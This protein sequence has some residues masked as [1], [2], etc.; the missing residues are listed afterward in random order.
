LLTGTVGFETVVREM[1]KSRLSST[2]IQEHKMDPLNYRELKHC[3]LL[4]HSYNS[5]S[6]PA[7]TAP[8]TR[9][10]FFHLVGMLLRKR[11]IDLIQKTLEGEIFIWR[12]KKYL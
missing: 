6:V 3:P 12:N 8:V 1:A 7:S 5:L 9:T 11:G 4:R 2:T 10:D